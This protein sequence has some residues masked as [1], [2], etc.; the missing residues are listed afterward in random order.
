[1]EG[2]KSRDKGGSGHDGHR[3]V[4]VDKFFQVLIYLE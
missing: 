3:E 1:M 4:E 2:E